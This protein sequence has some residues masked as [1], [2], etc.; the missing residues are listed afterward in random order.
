MS[1]TSLQTTF[2]PMQIILKI[3][4]YFIH[5]FSSVFPDD[6]M[7]WFSFND[8]AKHNGSTIYNHAMRLPGFI[9]LRPVE[10]GHLA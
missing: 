10:D 7:R 2:P 4:R 6:R 1:R 9:T 3:K 5:E 8:G